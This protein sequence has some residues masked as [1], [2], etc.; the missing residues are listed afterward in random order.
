MIAKVFDRTT[1]RWLAIGFLIALIIFLP[2]RIVLGAAGLQGRGLSARAVYDSVW[3]ATLGDVRVGD[4]NL[5]N[6]RAG[7]SPLYLLIG[8]A[9]ISFQSID[10][11]DESRLRGAISVGRGVFGLSGDVPVGQVF[12]PLPVTSLTLTD[13]TARFGAGACTSADGIV[14]ANLVGGISGIDGLVL[15]SNVS[16][17]LRCER[18]IL[19]LPLTSQAGTEAINVRIQG[20]GRYRASL[21]LQPTDPAVA[22]RL[23]L[24]GFVQGPKGYQLSVEGRF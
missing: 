2:M 12:S 6:M 20:D 16:G 18:G 4:I 9:R 7:L 13:V 23:A 17:R 5:G 19:I 21:S 1:R 22:Q 15:P 14:R 3:S 24:A 11:I 10:R 8:E